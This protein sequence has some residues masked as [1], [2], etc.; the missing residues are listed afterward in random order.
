MFGTGKKAKKQARPKKP[1]KTQ[2]MKA[3][4]AKTGA[5]ASAKTAAWTIYHHFKKHHGM[6]NW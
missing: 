5:E 2:A 1:S 6:L 4:L 3:S